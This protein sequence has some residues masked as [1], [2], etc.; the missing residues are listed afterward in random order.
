M[1]IHE[2][3]NSIGYDTVNKCIAVVDT[4]KNT[5]FKTLITMA[6]KVLKDP[7][8]KNIDLTKMENALLELAFGLDAE[9][10]NTASYVAENTP[11]KS[12]SN[13]VKKLKKGVK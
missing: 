13:A 4:H 5:T 8:S 2:K 6:I 9:Y 10:E 3:N 7:K 12:Y 11:S 1:I